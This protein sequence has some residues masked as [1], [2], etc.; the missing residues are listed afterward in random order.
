[1]KALRLI[2]GHKVG[3]PAERSCVAMQVYVK[4]ANNDLT[5]AASAI[6]LLQVALRGLVGLAKMLAGG[7]A[8]LCTLLREWSQGGE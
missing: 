4:G 7:P 3:P 6:L 2:N 5:P 8:R 1:M